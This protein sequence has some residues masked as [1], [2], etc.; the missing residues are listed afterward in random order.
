M[1]RWIFLLPV[2]AAMLSAQ[3]FRGSFS[4]TVTDAQGAAIAKAKITATETRTGAKSTAYSE[5]S[6]SYTIPFLGL[7]EYEITAE[8]A[9]FKKAVRQGL[10]LS[11]GERPVIDLRLEVGTV[12]DSVTVTAEAPLVNEA[13]A[14][15]GQVIPTRTRPTGT[16]VA[17]T[18]TW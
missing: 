11:A 3:E 2:L 16:P 18:S 9:G 8:A 1:K 5:T 13:N 4:G 17:A 12:S 10:T 6:G 7:G 15:V 14:S